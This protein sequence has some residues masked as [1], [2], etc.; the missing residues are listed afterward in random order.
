MPPPFLRQAFKTRGGPDIRHV[1]AMA[2]DFDVSKEVMARAYAE[3]HPEPLA[4]VITENG[5]IWQV[6]IGLRGRNNALLMNILQRCSRYTAG[7]T[8]IN[9]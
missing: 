5:R 1:P 2:V 9:H 6:K 8:I 3:N 4:I 7:K